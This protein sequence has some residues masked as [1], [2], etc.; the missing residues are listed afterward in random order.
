MKNN[1]FWTRLATVAS[2]VTLTGM[3]VFT[4]VASAHVTVK[5]AESMTGAWET[6]TIKVPS[7]KDIPTIKVTLKV[8]ENLSFKQ[9]QPVPGWKVTTEKND[10]GEV[11]TVTWEAESGG[12]EAGQFQQFVFVGQNPDKDSDLVWD[13]FQYYSDGSIVQWTGDKGSDSPH[14]ITVVSKDGATGAAATTD[15][16][17]DSAGTAGSGTETSAAGT[18]TSGSMDNSAATGTET[19]TDTTATG[20]ATDTMAAG[21]NA[22]PAQAAPAASSGMQTATLVI[23]IVALIAAI[24]AWVTAARKHGTK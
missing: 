16:G 7:E 8:P 24:G 2:A 14:S 21:N 18:E 3:I 23:A 15:H 10:A 11:S 1:S 4:G 5:P 13:A 22:A 12:I 20:E 19:S 9:Y 17:H 6:Y